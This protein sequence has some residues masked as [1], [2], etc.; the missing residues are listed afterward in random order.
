MQVKAKGKIDK[1]TIHIHVDIGFAD[2]IYPNPISFSYPTILDMDSP[3][4]YGY[5]IESVI[6]EKVHA[7][8]ILGEINTRM[9]DFYDIWFLSNKY[10]FNGRKLAKA[11][12]NTFDRRKTK[13]GMEID[14][15]SSNFIKN[16]QKHKLWNNFCLQND[17]KQITFEKL[18][19][20]LQ[21]FLLPVFKNIENKKLVLDQWIVNK[22][23]W[24]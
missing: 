20:D 7:I 9:K 21:P 14:I 10:S 1:S 16:L 11:I 13:L 3:K 23:K 17:I 12:L 18:M 15:F 2:I 4:L 19:K 22:K 8:I 5:T 24:K 6:A